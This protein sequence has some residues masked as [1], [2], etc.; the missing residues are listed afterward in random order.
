V[1]YFT[2][3]GEPVAALVRRVT[4]QNTGDKDLNLEILDGLPALPPYGVS[5]RLLK[6]L[7][8]TIEA[9]M[10]VENLAANMPFYRL[11]L[12]VSDSAEVNTYQA[13]NFALAFTGGESEPH[14]LSA[15]ADPDLV[16]G[17]NTTLVAPDGFA[18]HGLTGLASRRQVTTGRTPCAFFG[19]CV[20]LAPGE[21]LPIYS[22]YGHARNADMLPGIYTRLATPSCLEEKRL[23]AQKLA[24]D[25]TAPVET[26][27]AC[28]VFD[29]YARQTFLDNLLRGGWPVLLG[30]EKAAHVFH[31]YSRKHGDLERDYNAFTLA[32]QPFSQGNG[33]YRDVNQNRRCDVF[34]QPLA[35]EFNLRMFLSLIQ[36]DGY[37][38]LV[39][40]GS[41]FS[42]P[43]SRLGAVLSGL[44]DP[45]S[46][47]ALLSRPFTP[48]ELLRWIADQPTPLPISP[49]DFLDLVLCNAEQQIDAAYGEGF[50]IDHWTYNLDLL[51]NYLAVFPDR[52][53]E[54]L[55]G[56]EGLPFFDSP[57]FVQPRLRK[58]VLA[59]GQPR[60]FGAVK[61]DP[62]KQ[63]L[64][65]SRASQPNWLRS[66]NGLG[67]IYRHSVFARLV[68]L[69]LIKFA[70][71]DPWGMGVEMEAGK[72]G[73]YDALNGLPGLFGSSMPEAYELE[74]L[75]EFLTA[76]LAN[77]P[78]GS[79]RLPLEVALL[80]AQVEEAMDEYA[81]APGQERDLHY[82]ETV[83]SAR[84]AYRE[85]I[86]LGFSGGEQEFTFA[87]LRRLLERFRE[88]LAA[89]IQR[90]L[91]LNAGFPP[92][93]FAWQVLEYQPLFDANGMLLADEK[94]RP[95]IR[96]VSF[97]PHPL[98]LFLEGAVQ[99]LK[100]SRDRR[101][102]HRIYQQVRK[103]ALYDRK[104]GMYRVN[105][106][107]ESEL[108]DLGRAR[109]FPPGWLENESIWL[110]ME[111]KYLLEVLKAGL[112]V[113]FFD[114][115]RHALVPFLDPL[116]YGR[117]PLENSSFLA[118]SAHPDPALHGAGFVARL[119]GATAEFL[120]MWQLMMLG[121]QPFFLQDGGLHLA[122]RPAL[123]GWLFPPNG[124]LSFRF[125]GSCQVTYSNPSHGDTWN[126]EQAGSRAVVTLKDG[127]R[128]ELASATL[129]PPYAGWVRETKV[130]EIEVYYE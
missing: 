72:P 15:I 92:T 49:A 37:N 85:R 116:V 99:A 9:W 111:Y 82:W 106:S 5:D 80:L 55:F 3:P 117:S 112:H 119:S 89:G 50:W 36:A 30:A 60:Q 126:L 19:H 100:A 46:L 44:S 7:S 2:L 58:Y 23:A 113:Q 22:L 38:P 70:T 102:A 109:A 103:S 78:S 88:K 62:E 66:G 104:L 29:A 51:E 75:L 13:G 64:L 69:A 20:T 86:R 4:F 74:R 16:F 45:P 91:E 73:W 65:A 31:L 67:E 39:V 98:P 121:R 123:P 71:L 48:G 130:K 35:G 42:L 1:V 63:A 122:F 94:Q 12:S 57:A 52:R 41:R 124:R 32:A 68:F 120:S 115:A 125:L 11:R 34:F 129:P 56:G 97:S 21:S 18:R 53:D 110:H 33:N 77:L 105:A 87:A 27:T 61:L 108:P 101:Q 107:L 26:H 59:N 54:V 40:Q 25:L 95:S 47:A 114:D 17:Q 28:P 43:A 81:A 128:I 83:T 84:E 6:D 8:R 76:V 10:Q 14:L 90:A 93:Y 79:L 96:V 24:D 127:L 118:S